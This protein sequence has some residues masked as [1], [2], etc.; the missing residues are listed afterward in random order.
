MCFLYT[1]VIDLVSKAYSC[2]L[3]RTTRPYRT[4]VNIHMT[5]KLVSYILNIQVVELVS[6][7]YSHTLYRT[8]RPCRSTV[9]TEYS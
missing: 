9:N 5:F 1:C 6:K 7:A 3:Y 8:N 2:T 4:T